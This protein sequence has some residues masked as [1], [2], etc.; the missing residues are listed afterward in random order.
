MKGIVVSSC[1]IQYFKNILIRSH[2]NSLSNSAI[3][4]VFTCRN[5]I[6]LHIIC[7]YCICT[8]HKNPYKM[9]PFSH[10]EV[11]LLTLSP[12][13]LHPF[14]FPYIPLP[15]RPSKTEC[16]RRSEIKV[17]TLEKREAAA[18]KGAA[19]LDLVQRY[20]EKVPFSDFRRWWCLMVVVFLGGPLCFGRFTRFFGGGES[21][22]WWLVKKER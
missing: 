1:C 7:T 2:W 9:T 11:W 19:I 15:F 22:D 16:C 20:R 12:F 3:F 10:A 4:L 13:P 21:L 8:G 14:P 5:I 6:H 18:S 17:N